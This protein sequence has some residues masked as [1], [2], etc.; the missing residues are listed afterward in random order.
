MS[1]PTKSMGR[2]Q[3]EDWSAPATATGVT[4]GYLGL[5][6]YGTVFELSSAI[7][8]GWNL[9]P[10]YTFQGGQDGNGPVAGLVRDQAGNLYGATQTG[11]NGTSSYCDTRTGQHGCGTIFELSPDGNGGS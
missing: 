5:Q 3:A 6:T 2:S 7:G 1:S 11:G 4:N 9:T 10:L 8:G